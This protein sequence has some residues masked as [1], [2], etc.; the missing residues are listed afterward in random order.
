MVCT[1]FVPGARA[2]GR[3]DL[4]L[5]EWTGLCASVA[6]Q[7]EGEKRSEAELA[8]TG[9]FVEMRK[10]WTMYRRAV[11]ELPVWRVAAREVGAGQGDTLFHRLNAGCVRGG[12]GVWAFPAFRFAAGSFGHAG[13]TGSMAG[14]GEQ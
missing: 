11:G 6:S 12:E 5:A 1:L 14:K 9:R 10:L 13:T 7:K 3:R 8:T 4:L 2:F